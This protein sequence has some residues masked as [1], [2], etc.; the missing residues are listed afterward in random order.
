MVSELTSCDAETNTDG[1]KRW[2]NVSKLLPKS[3]IA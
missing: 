3:H 1:G 2:V